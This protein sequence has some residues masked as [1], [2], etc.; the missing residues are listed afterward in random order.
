MGGYKNCAQHRGV[1]GA[2][3]RI[4][5]PALRGSDQPE[6]SAGLVVLVVV[7]VVVARG[8]GDASRRQ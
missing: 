4:H 1:A 2:M 6:I 5:H 8:G 3:S 7:V